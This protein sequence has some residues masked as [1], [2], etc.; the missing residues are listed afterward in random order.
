MMKSIRTICRLPSSHAVRSA[1]AAISITVWLTPTKGIKTNVVKIDPST[2]P[3]VSTAMIRPVLL[4]S[5]R[6]R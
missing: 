2:E 6:C 5:K 4:R 1:A 3:T